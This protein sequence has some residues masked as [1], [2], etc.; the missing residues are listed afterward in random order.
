MASIT[1]NDG[2]GS[3]DSVFYDAN[4]DAFDDHEIKT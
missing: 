2:N 1:D 4:S 3:D